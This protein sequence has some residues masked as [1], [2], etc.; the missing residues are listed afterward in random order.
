MTDPKTDGSMSSTQPPQTPI[1]V[2]I[3]GRLVPLE[4]AVVPV[5]DRQFLYGDGIYETLRT[6]RGQLFG[7]GL[8]L[9]R[10]RASAESL[11]LNIPWSDEQLTEELRETSRATGMPETSVRLMVTRGEG[12]FGLDPALARESRRVIIARPCAAVPDKLRREG[13]VVVIPEGVRRN[14]PQAIPGSVKSGNYLNQIRALAE[15]KRQG[16]DEVVLAD[17]DNCVT[18]G[19]TSNIFW[20]KDGV[21]FTPSLALAVLPGVTRALV[22]AVARQSGLKV[23]VGIFPS[24][25]LRSADEAFIT[26]SLREILPIRLINGRPVGDSIPIPGPVTTCL[27]KGFGA[28]VQQFLEGNLLDDAL[29]E[30]AEA[31]E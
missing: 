16:A 14:H 28:L 30:M 8:H 13:I 7:V 20:V 17:G 29:I 18:E 21:L 23:D 2:S 10:L 11:D 5:F 3:S 1:A 27:I 6:Y 9:K 15:G 22:L 12:A 25:A 19:S 24:D 31:A 26:S 4:Q